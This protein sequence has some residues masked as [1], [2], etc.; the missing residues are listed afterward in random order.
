MGKKG[1]VVATEFLSPYIGAAFEREFSG[2]A[3]ATSYGYS[4][5]SPSL[6]GNT[7]IGELGLTITP[8][9]KRPLALDL[10]IQGYVGKRE[11]I[12]G[13]LQIRWQF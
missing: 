3:R 4:L 2:T 5:D 10:G 11:G 7:G 12:T 1:P 9:S 6:R 8:S 13:S